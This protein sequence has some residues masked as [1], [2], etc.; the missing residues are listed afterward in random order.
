MAD[1]SEPAAII[2][3]TLLPAEILHGIFS[4]LEPK[5]LASLPLCCRFFNS[6]VKGNHRL[7]RDIYLNHLVR[8]PHLLSARMRQYTV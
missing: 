6:Y 5:D 7:C 8:I 3:L 2:H 1:S 4:W